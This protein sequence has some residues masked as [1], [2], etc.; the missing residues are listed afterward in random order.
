MRQRGIALMMVLW[1]LVFLSILSMNFLGSTRWVT[2]STHNLKEETLAYYQALSG[3]HEAL[4]YISSDK[5][6]QVDFLDDEG[7]FWI[8]NETVPVTGKRETDGG[9]LEIR[10]T[11]EN[12]RI[13]INF[14]QQDRLRKLLE[15]AGVQEDEIIVIIDS[16]LDWKDPDK[17]HHLSGAEDDYYEALKEPYKAKNG[18]FDVPEELVLVKGMKPEYLFGDGSGNTGLLPLITT[19]GK[20]AI[21]INTVSREV[22]Q[23]LGLNEVEIE[24]INKQRNKAYGGFRFIP[25]QFAARGLNAMSTQT[26]RIEVTARAKNSPIGSRITGIVSREP[27]AKGS[28]LRTIYWR[29][30][31]ETVRT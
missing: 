1:V 18:L 2:G 17:E 22:M 6:P 7:N 8:D 21:N 19:F 12:S 31:V 27:S 4:Q 14:A 29:E 9:E 30:R 23:F 5:D 25:Q 28:E 24:T 26:F 3:Y 16:V 11:D 13:N 10:I 15:R 20:N